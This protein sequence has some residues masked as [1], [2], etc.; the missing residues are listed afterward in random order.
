MINLLPPNEKK[1]IKAGRAN[2]TLLSY[3][4]ILISSIIFLGLF[5]LTIYFLINNIQTNAEN[6]IAQN[7]NKVSSYSSV[8]TE[9]TTFRSNLATAKSILDNEISYS[10]VILRIAQ[11]VPAGVV[12]DELDLNASTFGVPT[13]IAAHA[14]TNEAATAF[15]ES[16]QAYPQF[17]SDVSFQSLDT[18]SNNNDYPVA[19]VIKVTINKEAAKNE[20]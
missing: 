16:L 3:I 1:Q 18:S 7:S 9:A 20:Q 17:F 19:V 2:T 5:T 10:S 12:L 8:Q 15:K 14:R 4:T 11:T 6:A 13:T